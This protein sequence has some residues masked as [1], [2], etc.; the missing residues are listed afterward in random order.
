M[1]LR[2]R[3]GNPQMLVIPS[4]YPSTLAFRHFLNL[5]KVQIV[6]LQFILEI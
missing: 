2:Q 6:Y 5:F 1:P 3:R 4:H